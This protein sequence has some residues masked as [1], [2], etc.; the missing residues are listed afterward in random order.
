MQRNEKQAEVLKQ[1]QSLVDPKYQEFCL[2]LSKDGNGRLLGVR[3]PKIRKIIKELFK[4]EKIEDL[5]S[6]LPTDAYYEEKFVKAIIIGQLDINE[7]E[8]LKLVKDFIETIDCWAIC[9][10]FCGGL[11][12]A[13]KHQ[14]VYYN[15]IKPYFQQ[16]EHPYQVRFAC[17][18]SLIYFCDDQYLDEIFS[19]IDG[20]DT[21]QY[22]VHMAV[23]WLIATLYCAN[24]DRTISKLLEINIDKKTFNKALQKI[25]ESHIPTAQDKEYVKTLKRKI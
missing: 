10:P 20:I 21:S 3:L 23:A 6:P 22:Y 24:K 25:V 5:L 4:Q 1:L 2:N 12:S 18:M 14:E 19:F 13:R 16:T 17:V 11:K 15:F 9:D 8:R 7:K